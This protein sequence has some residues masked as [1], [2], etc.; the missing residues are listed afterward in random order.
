MGKTCLAA[1]LDFGPPFSFRPLW[2]RPPVCQLAESPTPRGTSNPHCGFF[3]Q[4]CSGVRRA[5]R[6]APFRRC[7]ARSASPPYR[8]T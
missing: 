2:G 1:S 8:F 5:R 4:G 3:R 6:D 7:L